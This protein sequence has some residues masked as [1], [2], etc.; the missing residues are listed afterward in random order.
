MCQEIID[1]K[2]F[3]MTSEKL[4]LGSLGTNCYIVYDEDSKEAFVVDPADSFFKIKKR[5]D[6]LSLK[7]KYIILTH[8][9]CDHI[10]AL[11][12]L[13][14]YTGAKICVGRYEKDALNDSNL[15]L[16]HL[17]GCP[18]PISE[19]DILL[20]DG[21]KLSY[22]NSCVTIIETPGHTPGCISIFYDDT[23][24]SGD[25]LFFESVGRTDFP[26]GSTRELLNSIKEKLYVLPDS[27]VVCPGHGDNTTIGHEKTNNPFVW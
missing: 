7:V 6:E 18:S 26:G 22:G 1:W 17:F 24:I 12:E 20:K 5:L 2:E 9:H 11:D 25:T 27:T 3:F 15:N 13:K 10:C 4:S 14:N 19:A 23:L 21:D 8:A 16:C